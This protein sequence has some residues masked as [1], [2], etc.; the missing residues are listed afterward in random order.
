MTSLQDSSGDFTLTAKILRYLIDPDEEIYRECRSVIFSNLPPESF[1]DEAFILYKVLHRFKDRRLIPDGDFLQLYLTRNLSEIV[2]ENRRHIDLSEYSEL[3][4]SVDSSLVVGDLSD[5][6]LLYAG[7]VISYYYSLYEVP[8]PSRE[9]TEC[10]KLVEAHKIEY[11]ANEAAKVLSKATTILSSGLQEGRKYYQGFDDAS[12]YIRS[13]FSSL[14]GIKD[15][16]QGLGFVSY[17]DFLDTEVNSS[18]RP[19]T[20]VGDFGCLSELNKAYGGIYTQSLI[21]V[22]APLKGGKTKMCL[23]MVYDAVVRYGQNVVL[24]P[25]E[26][27]VD[28]LQAELQAIH[29]DRTYNTGGN[30]ATQKLGVTRDTIL[31]NLWDVPGFNHPDWKELWRERAEDLGTN[32]EYGSIHYIDRPLYA[33]DFQETLSIAVEK[34]GAKLVFIDYL[35]LAKSRNSRLEDHNVI[36]R[37]YTDASAFAKRHNVAIISPAQYTQEAIKNMDSVDMRAGVAGSAEVLRSTDLSFAIVRTAEDE[38]SGR[39]TIK[40]VA[41]RSV[42][43]APFRVIADYGACLFI[44]EKHS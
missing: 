18:P 3:A 16:S 42:P 31:R 27:S 20:K 10:N 13:A 17:L 35:G 19:I 30:P 34:T 40:N 5:Q 25:V 12:S 41:S 22:V 6:A 4:Q 9:V 33:E 26:G 37:V 21:S 24:W 15:R 14:E 2:R 32:P 39:F 8:E 28:E 36:K 1:S 29:F 38:Q 7:A 11:T 23:S 43:F 44:S